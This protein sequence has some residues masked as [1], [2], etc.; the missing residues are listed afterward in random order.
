MMHQLINKKGFTLIELIVVIA[1]L[2]I[3]AA[4][5]VP[6]FTGFNERARIAADQANLRILN[7]VTPLARLNISVPD[8][9][10][11][12]KPVEERINFLVAEGYLNSAVE[13]Q[14]KDATFAWVIN[15]ERWYLLSLSQGGMFLTLD[16]LAGGQIRRDGTG[17]FAG[18]LGFQL[19]PDKEHTRYAGTATEIFIPKEIDGQEIRGIYQRFFMGKGIN[20]VSF[21]DDSDIKVID[22]LSFQ[23]NNL[24]SISLPPNLEKIGWN[25]FDGNE[26]K[27]ITIGDNVNIGTGNSLGDYTDSFRQAYEAGGPGTYI[28][29]G[30]NWVRQE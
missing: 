11:E 24:T 4:I 25:A 19:S 13:A 7:S 6:R 9:F 26:L 15:D 23:N 21:T 22:L 8:P 3:I 12:E 18:F 10:K 29:N 16:D 1:I 28:W 5:A 30:E 20:S 2:G 17:P 27:E 14:S